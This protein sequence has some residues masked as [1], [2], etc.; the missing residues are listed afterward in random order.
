MSS[1][2]TIQGLPDLQAAL[3]ELPRA[4]L[5]ESRTIVENAAEEAI[6]EMRGLYPRFTGNLREGLTIEHR[7]STVSTASIVRN[8]AKHATIFERGTEAR[9]TKDG[10]N[11]GRMPAGKVFIPTAEKHRRRMRAA[12]VA[13]VRRAGFQVADTEI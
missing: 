13:L 2:L 12:Q 11:R 10:W 1:T 4:L 7:G 6:S 9:H 8:K 5:A 3:R